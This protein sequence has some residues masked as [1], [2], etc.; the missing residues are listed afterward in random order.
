M[1]LNRY[2]QMDI[3]MLYSILNMKL[4]NDYRGLDDLCSGEAISRSELEQHIATAGFVYAK[5]LN[6]FRPQ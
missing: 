5:E 1:D 6:Q 4:R 3:N 2:K